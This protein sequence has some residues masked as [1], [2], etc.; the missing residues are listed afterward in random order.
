[1]NDN[2]RGQLLEHKSNGVYTPTT[3]P[4][5]SK[6]MAQCDRT[7]F[8]YINWRYIDRQFSRRK[9]ELIQFGWCKSE[10]WNLNLCLL[11]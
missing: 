5:V 11:G 10:R 9:L 3:Q 8:L 1:M 2:A 6:L 7:F 4:L